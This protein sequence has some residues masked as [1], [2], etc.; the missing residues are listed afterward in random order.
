MFCMC[1]FAVQAVAQEHYTEGPVW[2]VTL[3]RVK[4][5]QSDAYLT[6]LRETT[7][8]LLDEQKRQGLILD[9]KVMLKETTENEKDWDIVLCVLY[10][11]HAALD[12]LTAKAEAVRDKVSSKQAM[13]QVGEK[14]VAMR[15]IVSSFLIREVTLK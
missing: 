13:Q 1:V 9:Y 11:N 4:E 7:K 6:T 5:G 14:R 2:R 12:S 15:E 10:K 8:P 3:M